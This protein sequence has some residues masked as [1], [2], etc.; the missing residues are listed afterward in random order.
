[1]A[2]VENI[3]ETAMD[4]GVDCSNVA[5]NTAEG[6]NLADEN[7]VTDA[8]VKDV[9]IEDTNKEKGTSDE[10]VPTVDLMQMVSE[11]GAALAIVVVVVAADSSALVDTAAIA[12]M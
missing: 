1:M 12:V 6:S 8:I 11:A 2:N 9:T 3:T 10:V 5:D 4:E 7:T